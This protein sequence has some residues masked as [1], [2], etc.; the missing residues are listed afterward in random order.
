MNILRKNIIYFILL[1]VTLT[2]LSLI[3]PVR[4]NQVFYVIAQLMQEPVIVLD[5]LFFW[6][7]TTSAFVLIYKFIKKSVQ[8]TLK[9]TSAIV[10]LVFYSALVCPLAAG[11]SLAIAGAVVGNIRG[12]GLG[13][14]FFYVLLLL[15]PAI[16]GFVASVA[17]GLKL[18]LQTKRNV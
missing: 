7:I 18:I 14:I 17:I 15:G 16:S 5:V 12:E 11:A 6:F 10:R 4:P 9:I 8:S 2:I 3:V 1:L 13:L